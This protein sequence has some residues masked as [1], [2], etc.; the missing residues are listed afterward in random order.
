MLV[1]YDAAGV[2]FKYF[3]DKLLC[4]RIAAKTTRWK[5]SLTSSC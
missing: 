1:T 4:G 2:R 3:D 5:L